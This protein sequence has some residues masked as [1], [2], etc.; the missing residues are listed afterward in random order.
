MQSVQKAEVA[1]VASERFPRPRPSVCR[2]RGATEGKAFEVRGG[3]PE[4]PPFPGNRV[5][6]GPS[7]ASG[8]D[9][10]CLVFQQQNWGEI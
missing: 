1:K 8:R 4:P 5:P 10:T 6:L 2:G 9:D 7:Q 3:E